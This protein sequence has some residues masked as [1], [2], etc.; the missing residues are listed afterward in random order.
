MLLLRKPQ[1]RAT[2]VLDTTLSRRASSIPRPNPTAMTVML[3]DAG[4]V[5]PGVQELVE[6]HRNGEPTTTEIRIVPLDV[7][8]TEGR[9]VAVTGPE[10]YRLSVVAAPAK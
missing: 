4:D 1:L 3:H 10:R 7:A 8:D 5:V 9:N 2:R 6:A